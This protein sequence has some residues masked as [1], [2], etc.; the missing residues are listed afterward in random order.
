M[1]LSVNVL[2]SVWIIVQS[3]TTKFSGID[4]DTPQSIDL[5]IKNFGN[6]DTGVDFHISEVIGW[7]I[8]SNPS[9]IE[10]LQIGSE[11]DVTFTLTPSKDSDSGLQEIIFNAN[12]T[13]GEISIPI[14][15]ASIILEVSKSRSASSGGISGL[16]ENLGIPSWL[17]SILFLSLF[18]SLIL[19][20][21][22]LRKDSELVSSEEELIPYGSALQS[23][24]KSERMADALF[25]QLECD[26]ISGSVS[27]DEIRDAL[28]I[29]L[30]DLSKSNQNSKSMPLPIT[31]LPDG[32]TM[33]QWEAYG[34]IWWE[35]NGP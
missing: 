8:N 9:S 30:P 13:V 2:E 29:S 28:S 15:N 24:T 14:S 26:M 20:G 33:E 17:I 25:T 27:D 3:E 10:N 18:A 1:N 5:K 12:S 35:Q 21:I 6:I 7:D 11:V 23:G 4:I 16:L 22:R 32:W 19:I 34:H 31:G